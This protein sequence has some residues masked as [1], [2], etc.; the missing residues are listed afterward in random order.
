MELKKAF[1]KALQQTRLAKN[2]TQEDFAVVSS[3]TYISTL[4]RGIKS[5]TLEKIDALSTTLGVHPL[6]LMTL[7][8]LNVQHAEGLE[9]LL[10][11]VRDEFYKI[12]SDSDKNK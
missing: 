3:R 9:D 10:A 7:T 8:Y 6:T 12:L 1:A 5:P 4:E 11:K 2:M